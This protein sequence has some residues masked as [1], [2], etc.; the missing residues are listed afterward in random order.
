MCVYLYILLIYIYIYIFEGCELHGYC[1]D[2]TRTWPANG[3]FNDAQRTL[4]EVV[5]DIQLELIK[6]SANHP[7]LDEL[8]FHMWKLLVKK[9]KE[10]HILGKVTGTDAQVMLYCNTVFVKIVIYFYVSL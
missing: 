10:A 6:M 9:L 4:Y 2:I 3:K 7:T 5:L 8:Y 1:S